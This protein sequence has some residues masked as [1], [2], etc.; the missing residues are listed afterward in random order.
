VRIAGWRSAGSCPLEEET[1]Q[2][3]DE[4]TFNERKTKALNHKLT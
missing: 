3:K 1:L 4:D 2:K